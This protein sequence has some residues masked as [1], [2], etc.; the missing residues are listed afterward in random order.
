MI[1]LSSRVAV[2]VFA[3]WGGR[4]T[5]LGTASYWQPLSAGAGTIDEMHA[6]KSATVTTPCFHAYFHTYFPRG[7]SFALKL[8]TSDR[9]AFTTR[10]TEVSY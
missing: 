9:T 4:T 10:I 8:E 6:Y 1:H 7:S 3:T 5:V 2:H